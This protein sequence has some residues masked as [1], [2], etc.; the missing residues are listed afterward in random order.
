MSRTRFTPD[1]AYLELRQFN[2]VFICDDA[3]LAGKNY[4]LI[5]EHSAKVARGFTRKAFNFYVKQTDGSAIP[6]RVKQQP[7]YFSFSSLKIK[8]EIHAVTAEGIIRLDHH[9]QNGVQYRRTRTQ[10]LFPTTEHGRVVNRDVQGRELPPCLSDKD[11]ILPERVDIIDCF[12]YTG[13][14]NYWN[15]LLDGGF[16][17][18]PCP[19]RY[20]KEEKSWLIKYY[21]Y[22]NQRG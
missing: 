17:F 10:I 22:Q 2:L 4:S 9:Y 1:I 5:Q 21:H 3:M 14:P 13:V 6:M 18:Q 12:M 20:P 16:A 7:G 11:Y 15:D 8:G 19:I